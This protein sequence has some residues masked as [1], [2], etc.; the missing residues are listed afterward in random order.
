M[1]TE[2]PGPDARRIGRELELFKPAD[3]G[4]TFRT[5]PPLVVPAPRRRF[6]PRRRAASG[7]SVDGDLDLRRARLTV[8]LVSFAAVATLITFIVVAH[9]RDHG[10]PPPATAS[11]LTLSV[12]PFPALPVPASVEPASSAPATVV[13]PAPPP[14]TTP[15]RHHSPKPSRTPAPTTPPVTVNLTVGAVISLQVAGRP[16][17][18]VRHLDDLARVDSYT[19]DS[20]SSQRLDATFRVGKATVRGCVSLESVNV[21]GYF[22][23]HRN[24]VLRLDRADDSPLFLQDSAFCQVD[25]GSGAI[26]LRSVNYP[27]RYL[28]EGENALLLTETDPTAA[29]H[30]LVHPPA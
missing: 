18:L 10:G 29:T 14:A 12:A 21:P 24:F 3:T 30:F 11:E 28:T 26:A 7:W 8:L 16:G 25:V 22:L 9:R 4:R 2:D 23:R 6:S 13:P 20:T 5:P 27:D 1:P 17:A 15:S 19:P